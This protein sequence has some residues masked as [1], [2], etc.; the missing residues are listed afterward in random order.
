M[1]HSWEASTVTDNGVVTVYEYE[2]TRMP[3]MEQHEVIR[4]LGPPLA[5][6]LASMG[7]AFDMR[8]AIFELIAG[9]GDVSKVNHD[10]AV[11]ALLSRVKR[12]VK[13]SG[14][15]FAPIWSGADFMFED[16]ELTDFY[17]I[18]QEAGAYT[19]GNF[20]AMISLIQHGGASAPPPPVSMN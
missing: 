18:V 8:K 15:Q 2:T 19:Y 14:T 4:R 1:P 17:A 7:A 9:V 16:I 11:N 10:F 20:M 6:R 3:V 5:A 12:R 13:G